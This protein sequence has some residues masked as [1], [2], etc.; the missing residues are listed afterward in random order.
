MNYLRNVTWMIGSIAGGCIL[1]QI[2][3]YGAKKIVE[4]N[5]DIYK[6]LDSQNMTEEEYNKAVETNKKNKEI[7]CKLA[8]AGAGLFTGFLTA[9]AAAGIYCMDDAE[10]KNN[11]NA[12]FTIGTNY[13]I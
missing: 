6:N 2:A 9:T 13:I 3:S 7:K 8:S 1:S 12:G 4:D 5:I 10:S 11:Q